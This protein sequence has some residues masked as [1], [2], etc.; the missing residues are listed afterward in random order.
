M[1][2]ITTNPSC[3]REKQY[4][5]QVLNH[6]L[7]KECFQLQFAD[8]P[9]TLIHASFTTQSR[10]IELP[11]LI[12]S[13]STPTNLTVSEVIHLNLSL[14]FR[15]NPS[16][17][18]SFAIPREFITSKADCRESVDGNIYIAID[19][20]GLIWFQLSLAEES[21]D[22]NLDLH[23]RHLSTSNW[24][25]REQL[26]HR[27]ILDEWVDLF[28]D[29]VRHVFPTESLTPRRFLPMQ[30]SHDIDVPFKYR[31]FSVQEFLR[32]IVSE[33]RFSRSLTKTLDLASQMLQ[34]QLRQA[35]D[36]FFIFPQLLDFLD[37]LD[38]HSDFYFLAGGKDKRFDCPDYLNSRLI[39]DLIREIESRGHNI[40]IHF[41]YSS[42]DDE[43][44]MEDELLRLQK[45]VRRQITH[46]RQHYL[47]WSSLE[48]PRRLQALGIC[49]DSTL[50]Y[51]DHAGFRCGTS[52]SFP[53]FDLKN[54]KALEVF[55]FPLVAMEVSLLDANYMNLNPSEALAKLLLLKS[56][57]ISFGG[58]FSI[59][60]HNNRL[61]ENWQWEVFRRALQA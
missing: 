34:V 20:L 36:P 8:I 45:T 39:R 6:W 31:T 59:L 37:E 17:I 43:A 12:L 28:F 38:L 16:P 2:T 32:K 19:L 44:Q 27:P 14:P 50:T 30:V 47:R 5:V 61:S 15:K 7:E 58:G 4:S 10:C 22:K 48:S 40:G 25:G 26:L 49:F 41:S 3:K 13:K 53:L 29:I 52:K 57:A 18:K 42:F 11:D 33:A 35:E 23:G 54:R 55:E 56:A 9:N 1:L 51:A 21:N 60:W 46:S 24:L